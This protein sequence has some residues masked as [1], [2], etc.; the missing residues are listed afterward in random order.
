[1]CCHSSPATPSFQTVMTIVEGAG[2]KLGATKPKPDKLSHNIKRKTGKSK[3]FALP[4][5]LRSCQILP[6]CALGIAI[7]SLCSITYCLLYYIDSFGAKLK[8]KNAK[9][10]RINL[11]FNF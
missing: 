5:R 1:M 9:L 6:V 3:P 11:L 4:R 8:I 2:N 10:K 7:A